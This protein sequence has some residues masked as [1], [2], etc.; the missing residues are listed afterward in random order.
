[1][2]KAMKRIPI[3]LFL[4]IFLILLAGCQTNGDNVFAELIHL[5]IPNSEED[6]NLECASLRSEIARQQSN[7]Q[8]GAAIATTPIVAVAYQ[9]RARKNIAYLQSRYSQIQ[10]DVIRV[11]PTQPAVTPEQSSSA[12]TFDQC[13]AKC[14]ELTQRT[15]A[16]CFDLCRH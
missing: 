16:E 14:R 5:P 13:F 1:M 12:M 15:E 9:S 7:A 8:M 2:G 3:T 4:S 6:R 10:C 11:A